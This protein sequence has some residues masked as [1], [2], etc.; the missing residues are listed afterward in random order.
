MYSNWPLETV[1]GCV[2]LKKKTSQGK[3]VEVT[4][5]SMEVVQEFGLWMLLTSLSICHPAKAV[6]PH[7]RYP[8]F[9]FRVILAAMYANFAVAVSF[10]SFP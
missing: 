2:N 1:R 4:V 8:V 5:K 9:F 10:P 3:A 6:L 7:C